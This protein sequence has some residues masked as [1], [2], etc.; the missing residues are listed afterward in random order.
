MRT[1]WSTNSSI[2]RTV[3]WKPDRSASNRYEPG[4]STEIVKLP[5]ESLRV[6]RFLLVSSAVSVTVTPGMAFPV[7]SVTTP[8]I[9][10]FT[11]W[12]CVA[13]QDSNKITRKVM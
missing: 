10:P 12:A 5:R 2:R 4:G 1:S 6:V 3:F 8:P 9:D 7:L 13:R 11:D